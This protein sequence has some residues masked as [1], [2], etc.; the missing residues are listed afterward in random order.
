MSKTNISVLTVDV[1]VHQN[2]STVFNKNCTV[3]IIFDYM[4]IFYPTVAF[5]I[6]WSAVS[7]LRSSKIL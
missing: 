2:N 6:L 5:S 4:A 1:D 7:I 3:I